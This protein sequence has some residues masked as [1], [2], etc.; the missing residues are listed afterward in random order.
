MI[1]L[2]RPEVR[3]QIAAGEVVER[4]A[5]MVKELVENSLDAG[6]TEITIRVHQGG[7]RVEV[8][9]NGRGI[10]PESLSMALDRF[11]TSKIRDSEDLWRLRTFGFRGEALASLAAVSELT[12]ISRTPDR[13]KA[14]RVK[15]SFGQKT[16]VEV[17]GG[18]AGTRIV[19]EK[20]FENVPARLKFLK[21]VSA[22]NQA[23]KQMIKAL[24][25]SHPQVEFRYYEDQKLSLIYQRTENPLERTQQVL[26][27]APLYEAFDEGDGWRV[28]IHFAGP[29]RVGK[30]S[31][32]IWVFIQN[33][34]VQD[35]ALQAAVNDA[36]RSLLMHG[37]YPMAVVRLWA[38]EDQVDV[39]IHPTKSQVKFADASK[40]F[41]FVHHTLR[42]ELE[43]APWLSKNSAMTQLSQDLGGTAAADLGASPITSQALQFQDQALETVQF[44]TK[45]FTPSSMKTPSGKAYSSYVSER[46]TP[47]RVE[48]LR[49]AAQSR[50]SQE[51]SEIPSLGKNPQ[52]SPTGGYWSRLA[53]V[54]QVAL[55]Y[56][57]AQDEDKM[58][59]I[60]QHAAHERVAFE[61][62]M[63]AWQ[64]GR[65][66]I[67]EFLFPLALDLTAAQVEA[68]LLYESEM[69]R[70][71]VK[72]EQLG[73]STLGIKSA[74]VFVKDSVFS[75]IVEKMADDILDKGGSFVFERKIVD[76]CAT[77]ACHSVVRAGQSLSHEEMRSL[78]Q[79]MDE[80]P[81]SSFCPHGRPVSVEWSFDRLEKDFGRRV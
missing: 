62:L 14:V 52:L 47:L 13:N 5:H 67:Q 53:V 76:I 72:M 36:Y 20:L 34:Y 17:T 69:E 4:P 54:G 22:E 56:I 70:L 79:Q 11:A 71:G 16:E 12:L 48:D 24:A 37:E 38:P 45:D 28:Q 75:S 33:R 81:L 58:L 40:A 23:I 55:T 60:D 6:A 65:I 74:P 77:L 10:E 18:E 19:I 66:E 2:L 35:R 3:D 42:H 46:Q 61:R 7:R 25:L 59:L 51:L 50:Q 27:L 30:T 64:G 49:A 68:V 43:Q 44:R 9:D 73:P 39:N 26:D 41:R 8:Q 15:S 21:S 63:Q 57:V 29:D 31:K 1:E 80:F 32:N 78:L